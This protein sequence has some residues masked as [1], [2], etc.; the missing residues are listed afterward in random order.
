[1]SYLGHAMIF[2]DEKHFDEFI[3]FLSGVFVGI[4][5]T[6]FVVAFMYG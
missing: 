5:F 3:A 2:E 6:I 4:G 1:M